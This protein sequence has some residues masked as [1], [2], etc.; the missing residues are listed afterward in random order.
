[1]GRHRSDRGFT[2]IEIIVIL[3]IIAVLAGMT[4]SC[5]RAR[6]TFG[7]LGPP[8]PSAISIT[9][10]TATIT[11]GSPVT[12][13]VTVTMAAA[14]P[15]SGGPVSVSLWI[16]EDESWS[17]DTLINPV[18]VSVAPGSTTGTATFNLACSVNRILAGQNDLEDRYYVHAE[19]ERFGTNLASDNSVVTCGRV[20]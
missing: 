18:I 9:P 15:A 14:P 10:A 16:D 13:T 19:Y 5:L 4:M 6:G 3:F 1:M 12:F 2:L 20:E 11:P 17:D 7:S 8:V